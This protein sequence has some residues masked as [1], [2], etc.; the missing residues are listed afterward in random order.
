MMPW[1]HGDS[2][3]VALKDTRLYSD[4]MKRPM[5][6][7][8][9]TVSDM[10]AV[11]RRLFAPEV[12]DMLQSQYAKNFFEREHCSEGLRIRQMFENA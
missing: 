5:P 2:E 12:Q 6:C 3:H 10:K 4:V 8:S 11:I 9:T 1:S 7:R